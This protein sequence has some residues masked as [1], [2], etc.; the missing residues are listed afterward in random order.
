[1]LKQKS[2]LLILCFIASII[3]LVTVRFI[4][5]FDGLYGQD[6]YEYLRYSNTLITFL[7]SGV[8]PGDYFWPL[9]YPIL[10]ALL[11]FITNASFA[12]QFI[13]IVS[14]VFCSVYIIKT[15]SLIYEDTKYNLFYVLTFFI[16]S[17]MTFRL[18]VSSMSDMLATLFITLS[19][20]QGVKYFKK[21]KI[22]HLYWTLIFGISAVMTRYGAFVVLLPLGISILLFFFKKK[23]KITH[24]FI[25][26]GIT[27][28]LLLPHFVVRSENSAEFLQHE[29][30]KNWSIFNFFKKS[31]TTVDGIST[32]LFPNIIYAFSSV[33]HPR[34]FLFGL[35]SI[36]FI[37]TKIKRSFEIKT[38]LLSFIIYGLFLAGIPFQNNRFLLL[39]FPLIL[40][41]LFPSFQFLVNKIKHTY[42]KK[43]LFF[44]VILIQISLTFIGLKPILERNSFEKKITTELKK[45]ENNTLYSFDIDI[46]LQG[47]NLDFVYK[48]LWVQKYSTFQ[49]GSLVLFHPT[50]FEKQWQDKNPMINWN[51]LKT[52][53]NLE[54]VH[55]LPEGWVL[56]EIKNKN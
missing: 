8:Q 24:I 21:V 34:Y 35:I 37:I 6:S 50:K 23:E 18:G 26:V 41:L 40:I 17:P 44:I 55:Y 43:S 36:P 32:N 51:N 30:L 7:K 54:I 27:L 12:L 9:Y 29:W 4:L 33:F 10:G 25:L 49:N 1:M 3:M 56:Y 48:N 45:Y 20:Y 31:F 19:F 15:I 47:R 39:S 16:L 53:Y 14:L 2:N 11:G 22:K 5:N 46:A 13:S 42:I 38:I 28:F 52:N